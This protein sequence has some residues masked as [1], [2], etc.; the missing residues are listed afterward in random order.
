MIN[1][2]MKLILGSA[3]LINSCKYFKIKK[4]LNFVRM[5]WKRET[6][7]NLVHSSI[8][9]FRLR[10]VSTGIY[11]DCRNVVTIYSKRIM[12]S[13]KI[14]RSFFIYPNWILYTAENVIFS[15]LILNELRRV[16]KLYRI[17]R[18]SR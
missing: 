1:L 7:S 12:K 17:R 16:K 6:A 13:L 15:Q 10:V 8:S 4:S 14:Y 18:L 11:T 3:H 2:G 9:L 5:T